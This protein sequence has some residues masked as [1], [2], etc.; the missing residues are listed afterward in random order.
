MF[1][2]LFTYSVGLMCYFVGNST[3]SCSLS[4]SNVS[5]GFYARSHFIPLQQCPLRRRT[6]R[7]NHVHKGIHVLTHPRPPIPYR[8]D[9]SKSAGE[10]TSEERVGR[11]WG[12]KWGRVVGSLSKSFVFVENAMIQSENIIERSV[13]IPHECLAFAKS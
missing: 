13:W 7:E 5:R 8:R 4:V 2:P 1:V 3:Q 11:R 12:E 10:R 6:R 9:V